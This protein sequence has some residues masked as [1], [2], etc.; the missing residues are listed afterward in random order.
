[1]CIQP[2]WDNYALTDLVEMICEGS[3]QDLVMIV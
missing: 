1:M 2:V 3:M